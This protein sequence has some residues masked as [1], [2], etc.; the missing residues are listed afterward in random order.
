MFAAVTGLL[1][2]LLGSGGVASGAAAQGLLDVRVVPSD[3]LRDVAV[4]IYDAAGRP[5]IV[6]NR[7]LLDQLGPRLA[8]FFLAHE[9]GHF[10]YGHAGA[11]LVAQ[12]TTF[13]ERR[14]PSSRASAPGASTAFTRPARSARPKFSPVCP[15]AHLWAP[16]Q[17]T[18][19]QIGPH[20]KVN[21]EQ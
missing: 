16:R 10:F 12:D 21:G 17:R 18:P 7:R 15:E 14:W 2:V 6:E 1:L 5:T 11:A 4:A 8:A 19:R 20:G 9:Y 13:A 3:T